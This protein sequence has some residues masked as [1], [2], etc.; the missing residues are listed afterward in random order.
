M[1]VP[2]LVAKY[3][4][5][6][7]VNR[8]KKVYSVLGQVVVHSFNDYGHLSPTETD[9]TSGNQA[10]FMRKYLLPYFSEPKI[11]DPYFYN[12]TSKYKALN[13]NDWGN[14]VKTT[15][16]RVLFQTKDGVIYF[17]FSLRANSVLV[18][19]DI[20]GESKPNTLGKDVFEF[21]IDLSKNT[22]TPYE[23]YKTMSDI[24]SNCSKTGAGERCMA[25]IVH[26]GWQ[27]KNDYP[28]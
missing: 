20:N 26:D 17:M 4:K 5:H 3:Q 23:Y 14:T 22:V 10:A 16:T 13:G 24:N 28:W 9:L 18:A 19:A 27:I 1:T 2:T 11:A 8:L 15:D 6:A 12:G 21:T 25:K 7:T